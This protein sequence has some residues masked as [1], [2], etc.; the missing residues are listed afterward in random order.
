MTIGSNVSFTYIDMYGKI[1]S[2]SLILSSNAVTESEMS[3]EAV[4]ERLSLKLRALSLNELIY[5]GTIFAA[6]NLLR[7][8]PYATVINMCEE[9]SAEQA[10]PFAPV[11]AAQPMAVP[12]E[13]TAAPANAE[14]TEELIDTALNYAPDEQYYTSAATE[15]LDQKSY[16]NMAPA[17][18]MTAPSQNGSSNNKTIIAVLVVVI[19]ALIGVGIAMFFFGDKFNI[20]LFKDSE[21]TTTEAPDTLPHDHQEETT[22]EIEDTEE[23]TAVTTEDSTAAIQDI[24]T[25]EYIGYWYIKDKFDRELTIHQIENDTVYFS[26]E[27]Y[28][29]D[30]INHVSAKLE[31][32]T[33]SFVFANDGR[34][35]EGE[36]FFA[37]EHIVINILESTRP[38]MPEETLSFTVI[39]TTSFLCAD[40]DFNDEDEKETDE[41]LEDDSTAADDE[42]TDGESIA[43]EPSS[44]ITLRVVIANGGLNMRNGP[45]TSQSVLALIPNGELIT[46][47]KTKDNWAYVCYNGKYGWCSCDFL[48]VPVEY[49]GAPLY[50]AIVRVDGLLEMISDVYAEDDEVK[51]DIPDGTIVNIYILDGDRAF[52]KYNNIY[53]WCPV[54]Y[55]ELA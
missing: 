36:L 44:D 8:D 32:N 48:F 22:A 45:D 5:D 53:G 39:E 51:V 26:L 1:Q 35:I 11:M 25:T 42:T 14:I 33:A 21:E 55:L 9:A 12:V 40:D 3:D 31:G 27:Y 2:T 49:T 19:I 13:N 24:D 29:T 10:P 54:E 30:R 52:I 50:T 6:R 15:V 17:I 16:P 23:T 43:I 28:K 47:E 20:N 38:D 41:K 4:F 34:M 46:V 37:E 7:T 18:N